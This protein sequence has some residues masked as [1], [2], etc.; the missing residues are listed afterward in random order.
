MCAG[1]VPQHPP[2]IFSQPFSANS[3]NSRP[4]YS[5][6]SR[7]APNSFGSPAFGWQ[8][9]KQGAIRAAP[10]HRA[11]RG[12]R[13]AA[14]EPHAHAPEVRRPNSRTPR[15]FGPDSVRPLASVIVAEIITGSVMPRSFEDLRDAEQAGLEVERV[16]RRLGKTGCRRRRRSVLRLARCR[17]RPVDQRSPRGSPGR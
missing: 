5:G 11:A 4:M 6:V 10:P 7:D 14:V 2:T 8:L 12:P 1:V 16:E 9:T 13:R 15:P 17:T 3:N